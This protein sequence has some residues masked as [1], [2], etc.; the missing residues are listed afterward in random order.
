MPPPATPKKMKATAPKTA[1]TG[2]MP[3]LDAPLPGYITPKKKTGTEDDDLTD[4]PVRSV[5]VSMPT[6]EEAEIGSRQ[7]EFDKSLRSAMGGKSRRKHKKS[8]KT[9]KTR[10]VKKHGKRRH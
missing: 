6:K 3:E 5:D 9:R 7:E 4:S 8:K 2:M 1:Q 10:K